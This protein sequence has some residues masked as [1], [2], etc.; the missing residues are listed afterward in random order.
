MLGGGLARL[1]VRK[2]IAVAFAA[3]AAFIAVCATGAAIFFGL[4]LVLV[5]WGAALITALL[6]AV[7]ALGVVVVFLTNE[8]REEEAEAAE[9]QGLADRAVQLFSAHPVLGT[10][11]A[12]AGGFLVLRNPALATMAAA[13]LADKNRSSSSGRY[14]R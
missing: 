3:G 4:C 7:I 12:L 9:S 1:L 11:A 5:P 10:V 8:S 14:R 6:F 2:G 13:L